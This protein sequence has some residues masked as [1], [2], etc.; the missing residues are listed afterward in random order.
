MDG[1]LIEIKEM[2]AMLRLDKKIYLTAIMFILFMHACKNKSVELSDKRN[3][4]YETSKKAV[5]KNT[6][7][8]V[9]NQANDSVKNWVDN[10]LKGYLSQKL[11][12]WLIDSLVCF[13]K[14][15]D[16]CIMALSTRK[17]Y[18]NNSVQENIDFLLGAKIKSK[19]Y[20]FK[21]PAIALPRELYQQSKNIP[22]SFSK[23]EEIAMDE[24]FSGYLKKGH[25]GQFE[26]N[27]AWFKF[28][29][30]GPGWCQCK[31]KEEYEKAYLEKV[32]GEWLYRDT[33]SYSP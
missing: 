12:S 22:L 30:E 3:M 28:H 18:F 9:F 2:L 7:Y 26:I 6:Y 33:T 19:W 11:N 27:D 24:V 32:K 4:C 5:S 15:G 17:T 8:S 31:T 21:G 29:F 23:M 25:D 13:N 1:Y 10:S 14:G 20:F 16:R